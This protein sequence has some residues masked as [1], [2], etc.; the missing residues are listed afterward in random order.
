MIS[1]RE[2]VFSDESVEDSRR[3]TTQEVFL[4]AIALSAIILYWLDRSLYLKN[5]PKKDQ[6]EQC[7]T[8]ILNR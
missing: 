1:I 6:S 2:I 3:V 5:L 7:P 4:S 8:A